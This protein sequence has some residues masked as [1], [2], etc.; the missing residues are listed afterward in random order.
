MKMC[1]LASHDLARMRLS[2]PLVHPATPILAWTNPISCSTFSPCAAECEAEPKRHV[3][4]CYPF[5]ITSN[6][7]GNFKLSQSIV[8]ARGILTR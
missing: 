5:K 1:R 4:S 6:Y 7:Y 8:H 2:I 3:W